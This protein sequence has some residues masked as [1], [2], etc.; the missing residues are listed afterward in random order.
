LNEDI[1]DENQEAL[2]KMKKK[3][4]KKLKAKDVE[5]KS[6]EKKVEEMRN[7]LDKVKLSFISME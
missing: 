3:N 7:E 6:K 5:L 1:K 2:S 4:Y